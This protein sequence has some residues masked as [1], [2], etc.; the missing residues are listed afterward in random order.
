[1]RSA[2]KTYVVETSRA[3]EFPLDMLRYDSAEPATLED[4]GLIQRLNDYMGPG[5]EGLPKRVRVTLKTASRFA[6]AIGRWESFGCKV[7]ECSDPTIMLI[8]NSRKASAAADPSAIMR[9][10]L[11]DAD[12]V[13]ARI[14]AGGYRANLSDTERLRNHVRA[15]LK[16][17]NPEV[18]F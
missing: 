15:L 17:L 12:D 11:A 8:H 4:A 2:E 10:A 3:G 14:I 7:V 5:K 18:E 6:P 13:S 1:M 9:Q 16:L